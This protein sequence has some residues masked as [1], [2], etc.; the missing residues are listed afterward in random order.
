[1]FLTI[2]NAILLKKNCVEGRHPLDALTISKAPKGEI[3]KLIYKLQQEICAGA[4][5]FED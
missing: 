5:K 4:L 2:G 3:L 1:M